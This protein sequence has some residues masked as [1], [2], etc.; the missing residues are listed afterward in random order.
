MAVEEADEGVAAA[1]SAAA[2]AGTKGLDD[3]VVVLLST[4]STAVRDRFQANE[5]DS[6]R[7]KGGAQ[8]GAVDPQCRGRFAARCSAPS[9]LSV[10]TKLPG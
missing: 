10:V 4:A 5:A 9:P 1:P 8:A 2:L 3:E 7:R 6:Q